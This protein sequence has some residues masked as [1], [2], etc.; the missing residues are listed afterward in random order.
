MI[1]LFK[2]FDS[3]FELFLCLLQILIATLLSK[4]AD[5][6][7]EVV[8]E[9]KSPLTTVLLEELFGELEFCLDLMVAHFVQRSFS[10]ILQL[11]ELA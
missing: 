6:S 4:N 1:N 3:T 9:A 10:L 8:R 5:L 11:L 2:A 7:Q